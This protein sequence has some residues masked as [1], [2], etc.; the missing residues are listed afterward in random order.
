[1]LASLFDSAVC[2]AVGKARLGRASRLS[3]SCPFAAFVMR[4]LTFSRSPTEASLRDCLEGHEEVVCVFHAAAA[5][6]ALAHAR[7][8]GVGYVFDE[9]LHQLGCDACSLG[10][11]VQLLPCAIRVIEAR[12]YDSVGSMVRCIVSRSYRFE[13]KHRVYQIRCRK[14]ILL[15]SGA[16]FDPACV[17]GLLPRLSP[18]S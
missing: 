12:K 3:E 18:M 13:G 14:A 10:N 17:C 7:H 16:T 1:M 9:L 15:D 8:S 6:P 11:R 5:P 4:C 2:F